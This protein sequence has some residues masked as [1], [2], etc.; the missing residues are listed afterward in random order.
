MHTNVCAGAGSTD[1]AA[2]G[3]DNEDQGALSGSQKDSQSHVGAAGG[4]LQTRGRERADNA[5]AAWQSS[6]ASQVLG[7]RMHAPFLHSTPCVSTHY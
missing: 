5:A 7:Q 3:A 6:R 4:V 1:A 2:V